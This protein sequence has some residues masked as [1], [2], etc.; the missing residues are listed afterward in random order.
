MNELIDKLAETQNLTISF[1]ESEKN[2]RTILRKR[3]LYQR[4]NRI[5]ELL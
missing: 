2:Q 5:Y 1:F 3:C 4:I